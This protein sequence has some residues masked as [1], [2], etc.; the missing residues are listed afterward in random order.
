MLCL[1]TRNGNLPLDVGV[2]FV[3][4]VVL[5]H[6]LVFLH[7]DCIDLQGHRRLLFHLVPLPGKSFLNLA[8]FVLDV[9]LFEEALHLWYD[10]PYF[11]W[12][13]HWVCINNLI[14]LIFSEGGLW[15]LE[16]CPVR[17]QGLQA[18]NKF[19][20]NLNLSRALWRNRRSLFP[21]TC[22]ICIIM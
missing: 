20:L 2:Y 18:F 12:G 19:A 8:C 3:F 10:F 15:P 14:L 21:H 4:D 13:Q 1:S 5:I 22:I 9:P 7:W 11:W 16:C 17:Q 6:G